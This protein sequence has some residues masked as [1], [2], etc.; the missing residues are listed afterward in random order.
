[1]LAVHNE[2]RFLPYSLPMLNQCGIE[3]MVV[4][5]DRCS[6]KSKAI[7]SRFADSNWCVIENWM[8]PRWT[9][10]CAEAKSLGLELARLTNCRY[11]LVTDADLILDCE[12]VDMARK[13]LDKNLDAAC[14]A[15][16]QHSLSGKVSDRLRDEASNLLGRVVRRLGLRFRGGIYMVKMEYAKIVD[17][18]SE[19]EGVLAKLRTVSLEG[20][21][22][23]RPRY[24][25]AS[26]FKRG[27]ARARIRR[28]GLVRVALSSVLQLELGMLKGYLVGRCL[29]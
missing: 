6:D 27:L 23:L 10:Q 22:H 5:L 13:I 15:Y 29:A 18:P 16:R 9:N 24:D 20:G 1:M 28:Y 3:N 8:K 7:V 21:V 26:Q 2:E 14:F 19:Y 4:V 12:A 17:G 11:V 25:A